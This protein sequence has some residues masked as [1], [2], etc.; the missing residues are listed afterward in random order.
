MAIQ[1]VIQ[2]E[3]NLIVIRFQYDFNSKEFGRREKR[4]GKEKMRR[5]HFESI[6]RYQAIRFKE[7]ER[8]REDIVIMV[9]GAP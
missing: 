6:K 1:T 7:R 9:F 5:G 2:K 8:E 3:R 4:E